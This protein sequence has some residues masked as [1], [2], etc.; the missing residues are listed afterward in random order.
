MEVSAVVPLTKIL[1]S[2]LMN[3]TTSDGTTVTTKHG[4]KPSIKATHPLYRLIA[5]TGQLLTEAKMS[6]MRLMSAPPKVFEVDTI[7][8]NRCHQYL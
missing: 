4:L 5:K 8:L 2:I 7:F 1:N 3:S 6:E